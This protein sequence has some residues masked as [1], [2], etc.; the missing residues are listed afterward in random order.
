MF[1]RA[2]PQK[3]KEESEDFGS[4]CVER[5][6]RGRDP[7]FKYLAT[8]FFRS[9][10]SLSNSG[11]N[12]ELTKRQRPVKEPTEGEKTIDVLPDDSIATKPYLSSD[13]K[14]WEKWERAVWILYFEYGYCQ[15]EIGYMFGVTKGAVLLW[16]KKLRKTFD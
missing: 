2:Y 7:L 3:S 10:E 4:F 16:I 11:R 1:L 5:W 9:S 6:M 12:T 14:G 13:F 15:K 8:D